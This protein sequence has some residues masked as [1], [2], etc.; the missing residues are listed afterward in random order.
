VVERVR[1]QVS[2][3]VLSANG[4]PSRFA[5]FGLPVIPDPPGRSVGP[6]GGILAGMFWARE[7]VP[8]A[9]WI[10][11]VPTDA[12]F[13]PRDL[14]ARL[15]GAITAPVTIAAA[16]SRD[17]VHP[18]VAI[19]PVQLADDLGDWLD[20]ETQH[21]VRAWLARN[22]SVAVP[23]DEA[24]CALDPFFNVNTP[25]DASAAAQLAEECA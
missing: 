21:S 24:G 11:S 19:W 23:F 22:A 18:V 14:V 5:D 7:H 2:R 13:L 9:Q 8:H 10:V 15:A 17:R 16:Q 6:L 3:L 20:A 12:P 4:D 1:P 25:E